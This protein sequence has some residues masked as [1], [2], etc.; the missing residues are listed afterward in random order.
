MTDRLLKILDVSVMKAGGFWTLALYVEGLLKNGGPSPK[1]ARIREEVPSYE[2]EKR[3]IIKVFQYI[4]Y[5][6]SGYIKKL[7][8]LHCCC[9]FM[10]F[11]SCCKN[12]NV[13]REIC[14]ELFLL[15]AH[16]RTR[17]FVM[18]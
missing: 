17:M 10:D 15:C 4:F 3:Y 12:K 2:T 8:F 11:S 6:C 7:C 5:H 14:D 9:T 13:T 16:R 1:S 18:L